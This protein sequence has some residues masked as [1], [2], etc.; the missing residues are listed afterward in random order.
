MNCASRLKV[1][2]QIYVRQFATALVASRSRQKR[3]D[4]QADASR[5]Q[6]HGSVQRRRFDGQ[7]LSRQAD[8]GR[9]MGGRWL[10][11]GIDLCFPASRRTMRNCI[12]IVARCVGL[13]APQQQRSTTSD[14]V[15]QRAGR[16]Q[17]YRAAY[18]IFSVAAL[19]TINV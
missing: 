13:A 10:Y 9:C 1:I 17:F 15:W 8:V 4:R 12:A 16:T 19:S 11:G 18:F 6:Q 3:L 2:S 7:W 5:T 14:V